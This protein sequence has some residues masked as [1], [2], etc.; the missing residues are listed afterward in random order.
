MLLLLGI[1]AVHLA[2]ARTGGAQSFAPPASPYGL[3]PGEFVI[4][5]YLTNNYL[6]ARDGGRHTDDAVITSATT[7]G[8]NEKFKLSKIGP[9]YTAI[10]T[11]QGYYVSAANG[12]GLGA[13]F[14]ASQVLHTYVTSLVDSAKFRL[15]GPSAA[16]NSAIGTVNG[17]LLTALGGGGK[18]THAF[19]TDATV[20]ST[21]EAFWVLK[22]GDLG[23]GFRYAIRPVGTG[24][25]IVNFLT[26]LGGGGRPAPAV[27]HFSGLAPESQ[28]T[29]IRLEDGS[30]ALQTANGFNYVTAVDGGGLSSGADNLETDATQIGPWEKFKIVDQGDATYTIQTVSGFYL[31][32]N[33]HVLQTIGGI[34]TRISDPNAAPQIGYTAKFELM[35]EP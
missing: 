7:P 24:V 9:N 17:H 11:L 27:T 26:A 34:S 1:S 22:S 3:L 28:F 8:P 14:D 31:G 15:I 12:G 23:S 33:T 18:A 32:V 5:T 19:H 29:L 13:N 4:R 10:Q 30:Y 35:M 6:T 20:A 25:S 2:L 21:W 16:G